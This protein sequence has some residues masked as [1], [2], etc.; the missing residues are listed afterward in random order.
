MSKKAHGGKPL[1]QW[2]TYFNVL[3]KKKIKVIK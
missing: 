1:H 3:D 2:T